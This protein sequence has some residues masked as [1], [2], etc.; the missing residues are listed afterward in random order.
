MP[1]PL[2]SR[3]ISGGNPN[4]TSGVCHERKHL[5]QSQGG[6]RSGGPSPVLDYQ[7]R[8]V[9][10]DDHDVDRQRRVDGEGEALDEETHHNGA[11][12]GRL[13]ARANR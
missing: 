9:D 10:H 6:R 1:S 8:Q 4:C 12:A 3:A 5:F 7:G 2:S 13:R 11:G